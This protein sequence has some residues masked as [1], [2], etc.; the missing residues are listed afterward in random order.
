VPALA[1]TATAT[2]PAGAYPITASGGASSNYDFV[3]NPGTLTIGPAALHVIALAQ[4]KQYGQPDPL[5]TYTVTG[6]LNGDN[7]SIFTGSLSRTP[8][9]N[10]GTYAISTGSL[11]AGGNYTLDFTA[12]N[13]TITIATQQIVWGQSLSVGCSDQTQVQ[14]TAVASSGL[15]VTYSVADPAIA[16]VS[17]TVLTLL[18][19]GSTIV[20]A[21][22]PGDANYSAATAASDT[23]YYK[24]ASLI[25]QRWNDAIFFDNSG[26][27]YVGW[28]W[29]KNGDA[30]PGAT[31]PY[32][33]ETSP[34]NG[35]YYVV[36][37]DKDSQRVQSCV[38]SI[39]AGAPIP[40]GI[41]VYPN[42]A[43]AGAMV[44]VTSNYTATA[45]QG[46]VLTIIDLNGRVRQQVTAVDPTLQV[47]MPSE[48][49]SYIINLL[50][51]SGQKASVNVLVVQQ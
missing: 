29:Y 34:L 37:T 28:Q 3:Y 6:L 9:E 50:L 14:L 13:L 2:S 45:L 8:G 10:V 12:N 4:T 42:P 39:A 27:D 43:T 35:Q 26:G 46:A 21:T 24:A 33:S 17:G 48:T 22:Q 7:T 11:S 47:A 49:G 15:P 16:S 23:V 51:A 38:L 30:V 41:K 18:K 44:T 20:T 36:A 32:Y 40:G 1:T 25:R 19:P 5:F 31:S